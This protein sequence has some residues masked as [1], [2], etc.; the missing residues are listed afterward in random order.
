MEE[1]NDTRGT[2]SPGAAGS[3]NAKL[4]PALIYCMISTR[5]KSSTVFRNETS[6]E[7]QQEKQHICVQAAQAGHG[8]TPSNDDD[9]LPGDHRMAQQDKSITGSD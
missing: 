8:I 9:G 3:N 2:F 4:E 7:G 6:S 5:L 1:Y